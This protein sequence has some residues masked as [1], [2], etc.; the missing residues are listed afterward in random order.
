M[1]QEFLD[2]QL[3]VQHSQRDNI[4]NTSQVSPLFLQ[5]G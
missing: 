1:K 4:K 3:K 2:L 5:K